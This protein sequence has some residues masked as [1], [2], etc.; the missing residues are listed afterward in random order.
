MSTFSPAMSET[1]APTPTPQAESRLPPPFGGA[2]RA[3]GG[4]HGEPGFGQQPHGWQ[5]YWKEGRLVDPRV[6]DLDRTLAVI[7]HL[8]WVL[9]F[10]GLGPF[11]CLVPVG[12][13]A[14][15]QS[16]SG[17]VDDHGREVINTQLTG[18]ILVFSVVG[19]IVLPFWA[20]ACLVN[21]IRGAVAAGSREHFRYGAILRPVG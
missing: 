21:S 18:L 13:W 6:R 14:I 20:I 1:P 17:F 19:W 9:F 15:L 2:G 16:N 10:V 3:G 11:A 7:M 4:V 12:I 8:W 5:P